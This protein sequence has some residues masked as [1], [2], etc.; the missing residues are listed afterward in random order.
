M[1]ISRAFAVTLLVITPL[2]AACG[3]S[4]S[5]DTTA[6]V[7]KMTLTPAAVVIDVRS[8]EEFAAGHISGATNLDF[9]G[10]VLAEALAGL[11]RETAY[12]IYCR[13]GRRS[14]LAKQAM[15]EAGF[16]NVTDLGGIETAAKTLALPII[17]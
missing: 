11:D 12:S 9:E 6:P 14:A 15:E 3:S 10:G 17:K 1:K 8:P 2:T 16:S 4:S 5:S 7:G 13:S